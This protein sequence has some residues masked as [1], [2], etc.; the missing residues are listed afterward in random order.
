MSFSPF[1][2]DVASV[3]W[4]TNLEDLRESIQWAL[5]KIQDWVVE[6]GLELSPTKSVAV[7]FSKGKLVNINFPGSMGR[8]LSTVTR[9]STS[10]CSST[11][12]ST[13]GPT[14]T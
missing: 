10:A 14:L 9:R 8:R 1:V 7:L 5:N 6:A 4:G 11:G 3:A 13:S 12:S 2:N